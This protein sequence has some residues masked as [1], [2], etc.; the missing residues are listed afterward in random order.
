MLKRQST[1]CNVIK[2]LA[3]PG[4]ELQASCIRRRGAGIH[5]GGAVAST[6]ITHF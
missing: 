2:Y 6:K 3:G 1:L 5:H 4:F